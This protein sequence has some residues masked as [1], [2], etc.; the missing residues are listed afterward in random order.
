MYQNILI[1][2]SFDED[3]SGDAVIQAAAALAGSD[4]QV[5]LLHIMGPIPSYATSYFPAG[6]RDEAQTTI[7]NSLREMAHDLPNAE[8]VVIEGQAG[9]SILSWAKEHEVDC[10]VMAAHR[11]G[12]HDIL[13]GS[14]TAQVVRQAGCAIHIV[15]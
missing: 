9:R 4:A 7:E 1:P 3:D 6:Y 13:L 12:T 10:I 11:A 15:R 2:L 5:T 14:T 8:G